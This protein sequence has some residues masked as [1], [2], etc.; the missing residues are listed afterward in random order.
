MVVH[1]LF[2]LCA[3]SM[4]GWTYA[5]VLCAVLINGCTYALVLCAVSLNG[6]FSTLA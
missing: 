2:V 1:M 6:R 4:N 3:V 5:L